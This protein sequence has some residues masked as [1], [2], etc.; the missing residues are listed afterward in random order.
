MK[1]TKMIKKNYEFKKNLST[2]KYYSG[3]NIEAFIKK[4][5]KKEINL[6]GI[7]ISRKLCKAVKRN[8]IKRL[9]KESYYL[10]EDKIKSGYSIIFL[11]KKKIGIENATFENIKNDMKKIL[12]KA[13]I[14]E[15]KE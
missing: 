12:E 9:I 1:K 2:G 3:R 15:E 8:K 13:E 7:A 5:N 6:L 10:Y 14:I 4:T 11:W